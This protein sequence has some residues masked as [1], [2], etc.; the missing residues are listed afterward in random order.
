MN[1]MRQYMTTR[2]IVF[3]ISDPLPCDLEGVEGSEKE[4]D[5][6][7]PRWSWEIWKS[8]QYNLVCWGYAPV[9]PL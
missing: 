2:Y 7:K 3:L 9:Q 6:L 8:I 5:A 4:I 1:Q